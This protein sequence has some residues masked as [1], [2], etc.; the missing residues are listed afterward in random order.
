MAPTGY[1]S[2]AKWITE[3]QECSIPAKKANSGKENSISLYN[4]METIWKL[5]Y[6]REIH[7]KKLPKLTLEE[8]ERLAQSYIYKTLK[9]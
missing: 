4:L 5:W 2:M 6:N 9:K 8:I 3:I 7:F 1:V